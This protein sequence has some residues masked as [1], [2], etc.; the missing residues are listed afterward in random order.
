M[1]IGWF[2]EKSEILNPKSKTNA[3]I[4]YALNLCIIWIYF[5]FR[6]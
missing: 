2:Y 6:S 1:Y 3:A 4:P 5:N